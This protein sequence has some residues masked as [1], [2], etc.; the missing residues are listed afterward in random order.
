VG[1]FARGWDGT[2][3]DRGS[4]DGFIGGEHRERG[5]HTDE[6]RKKGCTGESS[7]STR[8]DGRGEKAGQYGDG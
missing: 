8:K 6:Q 3:E 1:I 7:H 2:V 4:R 5:E